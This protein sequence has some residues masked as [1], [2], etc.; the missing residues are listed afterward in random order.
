MTI[1]VEVAGAA[2]LLDEDALL[3]R[4]LR[5]VDRLVHSNGHTTSLTNGE[6]S[7]MHITRVLAV[8]SHL[9]VK[10]VNLNL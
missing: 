6:L 1:G 10:G 3:A 8:K 2:C 5:C 7:A 4:L 9:D